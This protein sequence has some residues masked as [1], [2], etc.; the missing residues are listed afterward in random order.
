MNWKSLI[1]VIV[2]I[3][4]AY[5]EDDHEE[6]EHHEEE[7]KKLTNPQIWGFGF[8]AGLAVSLIGFIAAILLILLKKCVALSKFET[9]IKFCYGLACGALIGDALVHIAAE[10]YSNP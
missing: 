4:F 9:A 8:L 7:E 6:D 5:A 2:L 3:V 10:A 1:L